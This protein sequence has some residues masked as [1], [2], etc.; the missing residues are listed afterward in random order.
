[1]K[2]SYYKL[3][4]GERNFGDDL[5]PLIW[6]KLIPGVLDNNENVAF[7][8]IG[9]LIN[10]GLPWRTRHASRRVIFGTGVG[11]GKGDVKL[12]DSYKIY[13]LRGSL[14]AK[15]LGVEE[16]LGIT[17]GAVLI[18][19]IYENTAKKVHRFSYMPHYELAG[20][21]WELACK[22]N[23]FGYID[24]RWNVDKVLSSICE[25]EVLLTEAMHGAIVADALRVP[26]VPIVTNST[27]LSFKWQ[28]WCSSIGIE[29][30][31][32]YIERLQ[33][34]REKLDLLTPVRFFRDKIRQ[35]KAAKTLKQVALNQ[36][37]YLSK[38]SRIESLTNQLEEK[39]Y[40][41]QDDVKQGLFN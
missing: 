21:G 41:F 10:D 36:P 37:A 24:P 28:D 4:N 22:N 12:D 8:G 35:N 15:A 40:Q 7:V 26:W 16:E 3:P 19:R 34:P 31:P 14:S 5:N 30:K 1:M 23:G 6:E 39:L 2:L 17:D 13:C 33:N 18:R 29:Y 20:K 32:N 27:I 38:D 9:S 11:Y 25:T